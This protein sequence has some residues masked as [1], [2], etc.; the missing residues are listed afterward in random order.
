MEVLKLLNNMKSCGKVKRGSGLATV[1]YE[2]I[3]Y[4]NDTACQNQTSEKIKEFMKKVGDY[5]LKKCE[6]LMM[7]NTPPISNF[8]IDI[9]SLINIYF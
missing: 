9:V 2:T 6:K 1:T 7:V 8:E 4:L 3:K 5:K